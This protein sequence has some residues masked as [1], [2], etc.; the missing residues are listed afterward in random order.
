M[1][2]ADDDPLLAAVLAGDLDP[3]DQ[4]VLDLR[5]RDPG[6]A[7]RLD[8]LLALQLELEVDAARD[9]ASDADRELVARALAAAR[10]QDEPAASTT[11]AAAP[12]SRPSGTNAGPA[13]AGSAAPTP[14]DDAPAPGG[15]GPRLGLRAAALLL[16][17]LA[18]LWA[19]DP[20]APPEPADDVLL[21][22]TDGLTA[23]EPVGAVDDF[24]RFAAEPPPGSLVGRA[25]LSLWPGDAPEGAAPLRV[26]TLPGPSWEPGPAERATLPDDLRWELSLYDGQDLWLGAASARAWRRR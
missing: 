23:V 4:A 10:A 21:G 18:A 1:T 20:F 3:E 11:P 9:A 14:L 2:T 5:R 6:A 24:L 16:A 26:L 19:L 15:D 7:R 12:P 13:R 8:E 17:A 25:E 22:P